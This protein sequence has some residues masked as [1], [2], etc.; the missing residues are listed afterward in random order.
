MLA[1]TRH[2]RDS[3]AFERD[4]LIIRFHHQLVFIHPFPN[5]NGR[6]ARLMADLLGNRPGCDDFSWGAAADPE[7][8]GEA[9]N[10]YLRADQGGRLSF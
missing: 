4:E 7:Q 8:Q 9:R 3:G 6:H 10:P 2:Q 1:N 5:G